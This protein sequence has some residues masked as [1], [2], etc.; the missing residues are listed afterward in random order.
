MQE[1]LENGRLPAIRDEALVA[2]AR[3]CSAELPVAALTVSLALSG[4][5]FEDQLEQMGIK[6]ELKEAAIAM[7]LIRGQAIPL[8]GGKMR[9]IFGLCEGFN[10]LNL[11]SEWD[12]S[13]DGWAVSKQSIADVSAPAILAPAAESI[14]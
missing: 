8:A 3:L 2:L 4:I 7:G 9:H 13:V 6:A 14:S 12:L 5:V 1:V 10:N 11:P